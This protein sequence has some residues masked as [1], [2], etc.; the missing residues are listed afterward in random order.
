MR[1]S[2]LVIRLLFTFCEI[3]DNLIS[4]CETFDQNISYFRAERLS[5]ELMEGLGRIL[6]LGREAYPVKL[7]LI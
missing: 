6:Y 5:V 7:I 3:F 4:N 1:R 2:V